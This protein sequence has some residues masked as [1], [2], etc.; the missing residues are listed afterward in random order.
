LKAGSSNESYHQLLPAYFATCKSLVLL[1]KK[2]NV[3][4]HNELNQ[5]GGSLQL[6][7]QKCFSVSMWGYA[8]GE[9]CS[10]IVWARQFIDVLAFQNTAQ[11][12]TKE[13]YYPMVCHDKAAE[14]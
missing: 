11:T 6:Y 7:W 3:G 5:N 9:D 2:M 14:I 10:T 13:F 4:E 12:C 8:S 1:A